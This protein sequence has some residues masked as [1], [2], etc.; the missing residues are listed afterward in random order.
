MRLVNGGGASEVEA[1][2]I[3][4]VADGGPDLVSNG[5]ALTRT[6]HWM[7]DRHLIT[8]DDDW[9]LMRT[10]ALS[11]EASAFL[12]NVTGLALP[13]RA[14]DRPSPAFLAFHRERTLRKARRAPSP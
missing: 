1:A 3:R 12:G 5:I 9:R 11:A 6:V 13:E 10:P 2:H 8:F 14:V 4:P 7:F